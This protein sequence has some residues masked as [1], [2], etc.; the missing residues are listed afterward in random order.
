MDYVLILLACAS[1]VAAY[2]ALKNHELRNQT[3]GLL[4]STY[5][6]SRPSSRL[7]GDEALGRLV[8]VNREIGHIL[9]EETCWGLG[10]AE[11]MPKGGW[12]CVDSP[13][14]VVSNGCDARTDAEE[15]VA[16]ED[17]AAR[18]TGRCQEAR[19]G[20]G[21]ILY[22]LRAHK[23]ATEA[24]WHLQREYNPRRQVEWFD[25]VGP[26]GQHLV[27]YDEV[28]DAW[29]NIT[30]GEGDVHF[31]EAARN[32]APRIAQ[33]ALRQT[34]ELRDAN[35]EIEFCRKQIADFHAEMP[36]IAEA[37]GVS[38][39]G[40]IGLAEVIKKARHES[41]LEGRQSASLDLGRG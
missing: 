38:S 10:P 30:N 14:R 9:G 27:G 29:R 6:Y 3:L 20:I 18:A 33:L 36:S 1:V 37:L 13:A 2:Y 34:R 19:L 32:L 24:P 39:V 40:L 5:K 26:E 35:G 7:T 31:I 17:A 22:F 4:V 25:I 41:F 21:D 11:P 23:A 12:R 8:S 16:E 15:D 28:A